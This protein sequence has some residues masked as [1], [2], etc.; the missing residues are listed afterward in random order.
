MRTAITSLVVLVVLGFSTLAAAQLEAPSCGQ[1][2]TEEFFETATAKDVTACLTDGA[3]V[4]ALGEGSIT[5]LHWAAHSGSPAVVQ[6]LLAA[7]ADAMMRTAMGRTPWAIAQDNEK[8]K[9][10]DAYWLLNDA[11]FNAPG[12][13]KS[14]SGDP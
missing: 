13:V 4:S 3:D 6:A 14:P 12:P 2:N 5:P 8:L 11:R 10:T 9:G 7:G 1:W